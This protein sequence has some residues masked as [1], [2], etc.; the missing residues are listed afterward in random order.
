MESVIAYLVGAFFIIAAGW[1]LAIT[2]GWNLPYDLLG[3]GLFWLKM[4]PWEDVVLAACLLI[5]GIL[6]F[7]R[8]RPRRL[9]PSFLIPSR[10][11]EVRMSEPALKDII[12]RSAQALSGIH[13]VQPNL[14]QR[15][16]GLEVLV[17]AQ[18]NPEFVIPETTEQ[19]QGKI[20]EDIEHY[21]GIKIVEV[22]VLVRSLEPAR[23]SRVR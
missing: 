15:E 14:R 1:I 10:L 17:Y 13:Q 18:L 7:F 19:L 5:L 9:E 8:P 16:D 2:I 11:G 6:P 21:T 22:K 4:H 20:K 12:I 3:Q 23:Q